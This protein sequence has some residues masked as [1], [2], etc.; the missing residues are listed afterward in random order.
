MSPPLD[1]LDAAAIIIGDDCELMEGVTLWPWNGDITLGNN[2]F[3]GNS[4]YSMD[5]AALKSVTTPNL[6][7]LLHPLI[8]SHHSRHRN[9]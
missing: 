1:I 4:L 9:D 3:V 7:A 2:V 6:D 8:K 5:T